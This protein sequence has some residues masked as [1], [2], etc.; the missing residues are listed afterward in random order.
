MPL[1]ATRSNANP[2]FRRT[3]L[4]WIGD[5]SP[6]PSQTVSRVSF[7]GPHRAALLDHRPCDTSVLIQD[8]CKNENTLGG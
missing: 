5:E 3:P 1:L 6:R 7:I 8:S 2:I 4:E